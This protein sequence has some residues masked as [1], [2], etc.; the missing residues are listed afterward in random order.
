MNYFL[1]KGLTTE[2]ASGI[3][4][5]LIAESNLDPAAINKAEKKKGYK[6]YGR[7]IAQWSNARVDQFRNI[8]GKDVENA[9]LT[10]QLDFVWYELNRR[11]ALLS[12]LKNSKTVQESADLILRGYENGSESALVTPEQMQKTYSRAYAKLNLGPYDFYKM[13]NKR[14][15]YSNNALKHYSK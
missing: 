11:K 3:I 9:S 14:V 5:N 1:N 6:G 12:K 10:E 2:Q 15:Q 4:G 7:G 8:M 13:L